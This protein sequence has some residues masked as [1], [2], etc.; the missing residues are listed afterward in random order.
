MGMLNDGPLSAAT[1]DVPRRHDAIPLIG[2]A[3]ARAV[4]Q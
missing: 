2:V 4:S 3:E 1:R